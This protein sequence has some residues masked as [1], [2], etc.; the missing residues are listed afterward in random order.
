LNQPPSVAAAAPFV[1]VLARMFTGSRRNAAIGLPRVPLDELYAIP[2]A[3]WIAERGGEVRPSAP[4]HIVCDGD[5]LPHVAVRGERLDA[6]AV[7]SAVPWHGLERT[8]MQAPDVLQDTLR[9]AAMMQSSPIVTVNLWFDRPVTPVPFVGLPGRTWQWVFDKRQAFGEAASHL[10]LVSSG[11]DSVVAEPNTAL[12]E[13]ALAEVR[14]ALPDAG[15][16]L[17]HRAIV[18]RERRATFSLAP[19]EPRRPSAA[20]PVRGLFLAGDWIDTGLPGTIESAVVSGHRA[21]QM[22]ADSRS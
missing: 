16:A 3:N 22:V 19:G 8:V 17:M 4:A 9:R 2:A 11:A 1:R 18:V 6:G 20:T 12:I 14:G 15:G 13:R 7:I 5:R 10:S 21:A